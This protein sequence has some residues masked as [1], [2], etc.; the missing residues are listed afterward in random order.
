[1]SPPGSEERSLR[2]RFLDA[3]AATAAAAVAIVIPDYRPLADG[4]LGTFD[5]A[6]GQEALS[7]ADLA[8]PI[9]QRLPEGTG[10]PETS[11][12][13]MVLGTAS[14]V[15]FDVDR[16]LFYEHLQV[17]QAS[18]AVQ[19]T[20]VAAVP[21]TAVAVV[22]S[23]TPKG[24]AES[25]G[26]ATVAKPAP[27]AFPRT[28][29]AEAS[30]SDGPA[31]DDSQVKRAR[32][33]MTTP[34]PPHNPGEPPAMM[35]TDARSDITGLTL[36]D[37][38]LEF[39]A[40]VLQPAADNTFKEIAQAL[41]LRLLAAT[42][43]AQTTQAE[44]NVAR[45]RHEEEAKAA[46]AEASLVALRHNNEAKAALAHAAV[47][48]GHH[49][50]A[51][52]HAEAEAT[53]AA[54]RHNE[55]ANTGA[56]TIASLQQKLRDYEQSATATLAFVR[57]SAAQELAAAERVHNAAAQRTAAETAA[58]H[59]DATA[60]LQQQSS[61]LCDTMLTECEAQTRELERKLRSEEKAKTT[62]QQ[63]LSESATAA[64]GSQQLIQHLRRQ[65]DGRNEQLRR[66]ERLLASQAPRA[67]EPQLLPIHL[68]RIIFPTQMKRKIAGKPFP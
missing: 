36:S 45:L 29:V 22:A 46:L 24:P 61:E 49:K 53:E 54:R 27:K 66:I 15:N 64:A 26:P 12:G 37:M 43:I 55:A 63:Q 41:E 58:A 5:G 60:R 40:A 19:E 38:Q 17:P 3:A 10:I 59:T 6:D 7:A 14:G 31:V 28:Q 20:A 13:G 65:I 33:T 39:N 44:A 18:A 25:Y 32:A 16:A 9:Q 68:R 52:E 34:L 1:M 35:E 56:E 30:S 21:E 48:A 2:Q 50:D 8:A 67:A 47:V 42:D 51:A 11:G 23:A 57:A 4:S 62:C